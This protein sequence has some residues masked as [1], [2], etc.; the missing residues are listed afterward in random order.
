MNQRALK[1]IAALVVGLFL[2]GC[3]QEDPVG[4]IGVGS[5]FVTADEPGASIIL[6]GQPTGSVT[7]DTLE[8]VTVGEHEVSVEKAGFIADPPSRVVSVT[9]LQLVSISFTLTPVQAGLQ[10]TVLLEDFSNTGCIPCVD[11]EEVIEEALIFYGETRLVVVQYHLL[12]PN[13]GDPFYLA[14]RVDNDARS[15]YYAVPFAPYVVVDGVNIPADATNA[16]LVQ[17]AIDGR[18]DRETSL[19]IRVRNQITGSNGIVE[20]DIVAREGAPSGDLVL[21]C[22]IVENEIAHNAPNGI[23]IHQHVMRDLLPDAGGETI[24]LTEG[25]SLSFDFPY[26]VSVDWNPQNLNAVVFVQDDQTREVHQAAS[27]QHP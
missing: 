1:L 17:D 6:D 15:S 20:M 21:R 3:G 24:Q 19:E 4:L 25:D 12:F 27:S 2:S 16:G 8:N 10:R 26:T 11:T 5:I 23:D 7:P 22:A 18:V 14:A 9:V 13:P